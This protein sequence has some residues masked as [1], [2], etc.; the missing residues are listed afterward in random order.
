MNVLIQILFLWINIFKR[1][2][3]L[4]MIKKKQ[5][6]IFFLFLLITFIL[7]P[8]NL[9]IQKISHQTNKIQENELNVKI[10]NKIQGKKIY[11]K[12]EFVGE[13]EP[14]EKVHKGSSNS[15]NLKD[16]N[17]LE[18]KN[19]YA[20]IIGI[21]DYPGSSSD[22]S[23]CDDD[24][25]DV[26]SLLINDYNFKPEN[27]IYLQDSAA[28]KNGI[29][30]AFNSISE[31]I[32]E[33]DIL[34]FYYSGH[35]GFG[36][37]VG[38]YFV[39]IETPHPYY[40]GYD[41]TWSI[42]HL[43]AVYMRVH[44]YRF[45]SEYYWDYALCGDSDVNS[46][47]YY[48]EL[49]G[50][51][52]YDFWSSYIPVNR[53]YI[54]FI[55]DP[56]DTIDYGFKIDKYEAIV[57]DGTHYV[58]SYDSIPNSPNNYYLDSLLDSKL[59]SINC[60][61]KHVIVDACHSGGLIPEVQDVGRYIMTACESDE[62]SLEDP[63]LEHGVFTNFFLESNELATDSNSDGA[64]SMEEMFTYTRSHTISYSNSLGYTHHPVENDGINGENI[65][66]PSFSSNVFN[67]NNNSLDYSF[68]LHGNG[69]IKQLKIGVSYNDSGTII[70]DIIDLTLNPASNTGFGY[71][72]GSLELN[73]SLNLDGYGIYAKISGNDIIHLNQTNSADN[74][75]DSIDNILEMMIGTNPIK[76][77]TDDDSLTDDL[78]IYIHGTDPNDDDSDDDGLLDGP[79]I[80][81]HGTDPNDDDSD[82]DNL[83]DWVEINTH[84]TDP[85]DED[86]DDDGLLD[87]PEI[88]THGTDPNDDDSDDDGLLDGPEINTHGTDP[89]DDD[90]DDDGLL[91]G[92]EINTH[93]TDP[94]DDDSDDDGLLDGAEINTH[95]TD[96]NDDDSD[97]DGLSDIAEINTHS[98]DPIDNDSD[99][100][101]LLDGAEINTH[102]TDP[103]DNDSDNDGL[104]DGAE[105]NF[106][107][108]N[109][110]N[111]DT[112]NDGWS[113]GFEVSL[114]LNPCDACS[115]LYT[116]ILNIIGGISLFVIP[117]SYGTSRY[118]KRKRKLVKEKKHF[119]I[120][121]SPE[122]YNSLKIKKLD[123]PIPKK[124][125]YSSHSVPYTR[126]SKPTP[127][128]LDNLNSQIK[129]LL[130]SLPQPYSLNS[131]RGRK[132]ALVAN[133]AFK[134]LDE[135]KVKDSI[136]SMIT[137]LVLGVPEPYN[138]QIKSFLLK[139]LPVNEQNKQMRETKKGEYK[140]CPNC[141]KLNRQNSLFCTNCGHSFSQKHQTLNNDIEKKSYKICPTCN[142]KNNPK[143]KFCTKCGGK[144]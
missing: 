123:R 27:I 35:G 5:K 10:S 17:G 135:G 23:Y 94:N 36:S 12:N 60:S 8:S 102:S 83:L 34:F 131:E 58:C 44:F 55:S 130:N 78:E 14:F 141:K 143:N 133:L 7:I 138:T 100:D 56:W 121:L 40:N 142:S 103:N 54:R 117:A 109:P 45:S 24:A 107:G 116:I 87:G 61:E 19:A 124:N 95:N 74:D 85:N 127:M 3:K 93:A 4:K 86:S 115:S 91:D 101:G 92:P 76:N 79:E 68:N 80:N 33:N 46:G 108:S 96:P 13:N 18:A 48:E 113:D 63:G 75:F 105:I 22:L 38:P 106:H 136:D 57:D 90:S 81:T 53:Y 82:D 52:G 71:Y 15:K 51:L 120:K 77:D 26:Y 39:N 43:D 97:D 21:S 32:T 29:S 139:I 37:E 16:P 111:W 20:I 72:N 50:N 110:L 49:S 31:N 1:G 119:K 2:K 41:N 129:N 28:T 11:K 64:I 59:D 104:L 30:S 125:L 84:G 47:Y 99:D 66:Y 69:R 67:L 25:Q 140:Q 137:A 42:S 132:A 112:D 144:I 118:F 89:N 122:T 128:N 114:G 6:S 126:Y 88:N 134:Y 98:T 65:L 9:N 73:E 70:S 62:S